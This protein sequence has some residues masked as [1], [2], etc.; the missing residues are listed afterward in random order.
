[1]PKVE[2]DTID[3]SLCLLLTYTLPED[4]HP[5]S[6]RLAL[7]DVVGAQRSPLLCPLSIAGLGGKVKG[8][9]PVCQLAQGRPGREYMRTTRSFTF[10][11]A[12]RR[13]S[14]RK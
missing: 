9:E 2:V 11:E 14:Q 4:L 12:Q 3:L 1:M 5:I 13:K 7:R 8:R 6:V 10:S